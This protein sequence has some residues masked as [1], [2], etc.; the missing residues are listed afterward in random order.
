MKILISGSTGFIGSAACAHFEKSGHDVI[1]LV[2][3]PTTDDTSVRWNPAAGTIES[4]PDG[5]DAVIHLAGENISGRWSQEKKKRIYDSRIK[6]TQLLAEHIAGMTKKPKI[7]ICASAVGYYGDRGDSVL[8]EADSPGNS[9]LSTVCRD[10]EAAAEPAVQADIRTV[11]LRLAMV[12]AGDGGA[13]SKMLGV[14]NKGMGGPL[15]NG[16]QWVSWVSLIDVL[17]SIDFILAG[18]SLHGP[19][20]IVAPQPVRNRAFTKC[21]GH[22]LHRPAIIPVPGTMLRLIFGDFA[23]ETLLASTRAVPEKL[24]E[25]GFNFQH[26]ELEPFLSGIVNHMQ[27]KAEQ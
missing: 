14:F 7:F 2:R 3:H 6:S 24:L 15:G 18:D 23:Q 27:G 13:L 10:W 1:R 17:R 8:T 9:F 12:L 4:L 19:V 22:A 25:A 5:T 16:R 21:L 20:N 26:A 11:N